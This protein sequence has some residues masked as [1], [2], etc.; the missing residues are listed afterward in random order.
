[1][2]AATVADKTDRQ[3]WPMLVRSF[4]LSVMTSDQQEVVTHGGPLA[5]PETVS[6]YVTTRPTDGSQISMEWVSSS[7]ANGTVTLRFYSDGL[8]DLTGAVVRVHLTFLDH[9]A[10]DGSTVTVS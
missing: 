6:F 10:Q 1:M 8:G 4:E 7:T 9:A 5:T 2:A 3:N